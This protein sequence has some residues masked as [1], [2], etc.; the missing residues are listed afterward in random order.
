MPTP[1]E[2][3]A[4]TSRIDDLQRR[5]ND[6]Q[7]EVL[8]AGVKDAL[9]DLD[10]LIGQLDK[11]IGEVRTAGYVFGA[12]LEPGAKALQSQ[13]PGLRANAQR[14]VTTQAPSLQAALRPV[15]AQVR[16]LNAKRANYAA[17]KALAPSVQAAVEALDAKVKAAREAIEGSYDKFRGEANKLKAR[18]DAAKLMLQRVAEA[19]FRLLP[20]EGAVAA[21]PAKWDRDGKDDPKGLLYLT[22]Q[23]LVFEQKEEVATKKLLFITTEKEQ[24]HQLLLEVPVAD[25]DEVKA[26]K[27]GLLGHEDHLDLA[28]SAN[29]AVRAAHFHLEGQASH[30]WQA[31]L[32]RA[33]S[34]ELD[35]DRAVKVDQTVLERV[36][37]AP[38]KCATCGAAFTK[39]VLRGQSEITCEFCGTVTRF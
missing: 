28:F 36:A 33:K 35:K 9:E 4:L 23:R 22:D 38:T 16:D 3:Q 17:A 8:L 7:R 21:V 32:G 14:Q 1:E 26:S 2:T 27:K 25:V 20:T 5:V 37:S 11:L 12:D 31:L 39:P 18:L 30:E 24:V 29:A 6:L 15:E 34:K 19:K 10:T 13:W